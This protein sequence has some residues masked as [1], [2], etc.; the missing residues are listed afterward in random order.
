MSIEFGNVQGLL[1]LF[2]TLAV[3]EYQDAK[4]H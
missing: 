3:N 1:A 4:K 2:D